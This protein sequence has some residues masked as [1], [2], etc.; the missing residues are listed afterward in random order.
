MDDGHS[1]DSPKYQVMAHPILLGKYEITLDEKTISYTLKRSFRARLIWLSIKHKTGLTVTIPH[2]YPLK[3]LPA[4][5]KS[6]SAWIL[7]HLD[8]RRDQIPTAQTIDILPVNTI[9]YLGKCITVMQERNNSGPTAVKLKQNNLII[10][11]NPS[12]KEQSL[13]ELKL[14]YRTQARRMLQTKV[15]KFSHQIGVDYNR[16]VVRDQRTRWASCSCRRNLNFN[17]RLMMAPEPVLDYVVVHELCHLKEMS[18][19]KSFWN[20]VAHYCPQWHEHRSWL[21]DHCNELNSSF[22]NLT[23]V[24]N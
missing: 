1:P 7:R 12:S 21:D 10:S 8:R 18:H 17:W 24:F 9:S 23:P 15:K 19:S 2:Y 22:A 4:Y 14:W 5:L 6:N 3:H 13:F 20:L 11:L 16:I